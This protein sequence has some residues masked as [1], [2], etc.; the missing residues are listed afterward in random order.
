M[1]DILDGVRRSVAMSA[2]ARSVA[3]RLG[4]AWMRRH[5][6]DLITAVSPRDA[7]Y[8]G[9]A[10]VTYF[11][12]GADALSLV[13]QSLLLAEIGEPAAVLDL[14][15]GYGRVLRWL[16]AEWPEASITA[17][18]LDRDAVDFCRRAF[19]V[20]GLYSAVDLGRVDLG[21]PYDLVWVGSLLTHLDR[22]AW[23]PALTALA[24]ALRPG[25]VLVF[26][27]HGQEHRER[28]IRD[29]YPM[30]PTD[31]DR[32]L[33]GWE[34]DGFGYADYPDQTGYGISLS[35]P[36]WVTATVGR[37]AGIEQMAFW[38]SG[39]NHHQDVFAYRRTDG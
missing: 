25:G 5:K 34:Q 8:H 23:V 18:D 20:Q 3:A 21:G 16:R 31:R 7:M 39:W 1:T 4:G 24:G 15:C 33:A 32:L 9:L 30:D 11:A 37:V 2:P 19:G 6:P 12:V 13:R 22:D 36:A 35:R 38:I 28:V 14:P 17:C 27:T 26:T 10:S 29:R